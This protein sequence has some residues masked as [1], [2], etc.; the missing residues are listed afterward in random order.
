MC[1]HSRHHIHTINARVLYEY[2]RYT[3][4]KGKNGLFIV[5]L[6]QNLVLSKHRKIYFSPTVGHIFQ[7]ISMGA[8]EKCRLTIF[9][10]FA[11]VAWKFPRNYFHNFRA[12]MDAFVYLYD[13]VRAIF[14][15]RTTFDVFFFRLSA[16][17][18]SNISGYFASCVVRF[19]FDS[20]SF[21]PYA[22]AHL[23]ARVCARVRAGRG[24][25]PDV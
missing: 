6:G 13:V 23:R 16:L 22:S 11:W 18:L 10:G 19:A 3:R 25:W 21:V 15:F 17:L 24:M 12:K 7:R 9:H 20:R 8:S 5:S 4:S 1:L 14:S 2:G